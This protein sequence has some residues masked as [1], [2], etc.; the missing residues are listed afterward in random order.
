MMRMKKKTTS[1]G[2]EKY[3]TIFPHKPFNPMPPIPDMALTIDIS[4][5]AL[6][7]TKDPRFDKFI[8]T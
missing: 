4:S 2:P 8:K 6:G 1:S 5:D 7:A 3:S